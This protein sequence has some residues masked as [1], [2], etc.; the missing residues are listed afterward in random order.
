MT[1][2]G[3]REPQPHPPTHRSRGTGEVRRQVVTCPRCRV[4]ACT[5][6][7]CT[8]S[9]EA[10]VV[11]IKRASAMYSIFRKMSY[12]QML[13]IF[14]MCLACFGFGYLINNHACKECAFNLDDDLRIHIHNR[15]L[16]ALAT[17][18]DHD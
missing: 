11:A 3:S 17:Y 16:F 1:V 8:R 9:A 13:R 7:M 10:H 14:M 18:T 4:I 5:S 2:V 12:F 6:W 15:D